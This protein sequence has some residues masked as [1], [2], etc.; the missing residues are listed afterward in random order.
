[1]RGDF[2]IEDNVEDVAVVL[3]PHNARY[4]RITG[5]AVQV[6]TKSGGNTF[7]G[8]IR[9]SFSRSSWGAG[10]AADGQNGTSDGS[11]RDWFAT[12]SGPV[13]KDRLWFNYATHLKPSASAFNTIPNN[14]PYARRTERTGNDA[15]DALTA[16]PVIGGKTWG[17]PKLDSSKGYNDKSTFGFHELKLTLAVTESQKLQ[18][19]GSYNKNEESRAGDSNYMF[20]TQPSPYREVE[21]RMGVSYDLLLGGST[22]LEV[23]AGRQKNVSYQNSGDTS[24]D[25]TNT[26]VT[27]LLDREGATMANHTWATLGNPT[28]TGR[29]GEP[30]AFNSTTASFNLKLYRDLFGLAHDI[31]AGAD[32]ISSDTHSSAY[33]GTNF[34]TVTVGGIYED[35]S[36]PGS[37]LFPVVNWAGKN[38]F[39]Q[40]ASGNSGLAP[41]MVQYRPSNAVMLN[42]NLGLYLNDQVTLSSKVNLMLG[43][44]VDKSQAKDDT[45]NRSILSAT[46]VSPRFV[47]TYDVK[48]DG[49]HVLKFDYVRLF[50]DFPPFLTNNM[51]G[52]SESMSARSGWTGNAAMP[53]DTSDIVNGQAMNGLRFVTLDALL[54]PANYKATYDF[55]DGTK[56]F[57]VDSG[58]KPT[59]TDELALEYRRAFAPGSYLRMAGIYRKTGD[60][61]AFSKSYGDWATVT[62]A[63]GIRPK[64][65]QVTRVFNSTDVWKDYH[66]LEIELVSRVNAYFTWRLGYTYASLKGNDKAL[67]SDD[68]GSM[69]DTRANGYFAFRDLLTSSAMKLPVSAYSPSGSLN[70]ERPHTATFV[71]MIT[72][73]MGQGW[74]SYA[75]NFSYV[76]GS[77]WSAIRD[78]DLALDATTQAWYD[79]KNTAYKNDQT[80]SNPTV[81]APIAAPGT[82]SRY[83]SN[84]GA[85]HQNDQYGL[86]LIIAMETPLGRGVKFFSQVKVKNLTNH[87]YQMFYDTTTYTNSGKVL[88]VD[89]TVFGTSLPGYPDQG[90][91][92]SQ[93]RTVTF[94]A[95]MKF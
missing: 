49:A 82:Y 27:V 74:M 84:R 15:I 65:V 86:D 53:G 31:D 68:Y 24:K 43:L 62:G 34:R 13:I 78:S 1:V 54:N 30:E 87:I 85:Y 69:L 93:P 90:G 35:P 64:N 19:S 7:E 73:P 16:A 33:F 8:S 47:V 14:V 46:T 9:S 61:I 41:V 88:N 83:Y 11:T 25:P 80:S 89:P 39:G 4:G 37:F 29:G 59:H 92:Y 38:L 60:M 56:G 79:A 77:N 32:Y 17:L 36:N 5:G 2:F 91:S 48:G 52:K 81:P 95:G 58:L 55:T 21:Q 63:A 12:I 72:L 94:S 67:E 26:P 71:P 45:Y 10:S 50:S 44:R 6:V 23:Q 18:F 28:G 42:T 40:S 57:Q 51:F 76:S 75:L 70:N 20:L 66:G 22:F 3:S